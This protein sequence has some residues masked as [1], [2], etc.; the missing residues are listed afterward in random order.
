MVFEVRDLWPEAPI[1]LGELRN[2]L[3]RGLSLAL[4]RL[5][6]SR[7]ARIVALSP[8]MGQGVLSRGYP[9]GRISV[10]PNA[11]DLDLFEGKE[12]DGEVWRQTFPWLGKRRLV[13]YCGTL[14]RVNN[15][16]YIAE[17]AAEM[18]KL[19]DEVRF[20]VVGDGAEQVKVRQCARDLGVLDETFFMMGSI[21]K[22]S[23]PA[24][25]AAA[26]VTMSTVAP[27]PALAANSA[28][29][30]FDSLA[31]GKPIVINHGGWQA[32]VLHNSGAGIVLDAHDRA[33]AAGHLYDFLKNNERLER[34]SAAAK[35]LAINKYSRDDL[36]EQLRVVLEGAV[37]DRSSKL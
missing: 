3:L 32:E 23:V 19:D 22:V 7:S 13:L 26:T 9:A 5:A 31:A 35:W 12:K 8:T 18:R 33:A 15:V 24:L 17:L 28:N 20:V 29:K 1:A 10:I 16:S 27:I 34:A 36:A 4:E 6:Y 25:F 2:P 21:P 37:V 11:A 30:F 14:G